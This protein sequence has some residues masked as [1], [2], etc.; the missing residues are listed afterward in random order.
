MAKSG[1]PS[2][3]VDKTPEELAKEKKDGK[4]G[5]IGGFLSM[6]PTIA[7]SIPALMQSKQA[8][9]LKAMQRGQGGGAVAARQTGSEAARRVLGASTAQPSSGRGGNLREGLRAADQLTQRGAQAAGIIGARENVLATNALMQNENRRRM[10]GLQLGAGLGGASASALAT[11][12][13]AKDQ[14]GAQKPAPMPTPPPLEVPAPG[15]VQLGQP[16]LAQ[17]PT[18]SGAA[19]YLQT[20]TPGSPES[21][22]RPLQPPQALEAQPGQGPGGAGVTQP[23]PQTQLK[24]PMSQFDMN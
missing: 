23:V 20:G 13:A 5:V 19:P 12:L 24:Q 16:E 4:G 18:S 14:R 7:G 9:N 17:S 8:G 2:N 15:E 1:Y 11:M 10:L 3:V 6:L 21:F 22:G